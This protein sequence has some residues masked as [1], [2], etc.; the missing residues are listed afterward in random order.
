MP[1]H[2]IDRG[3]T[4]TNDNDRRDAIRRRVRRKASVEINDG[5]W[6]FPA[7]V[8]QI[9]LDGARVE[10]ERPHVTPEYLTLIVDGERKS[11][12]RVWQSEKL[13]GVQFDRAG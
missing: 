9:S 6:T 12:R 7:N 5:W 13:L 4:E 3:W 2:G 11:C 10:M 1:G 8:T